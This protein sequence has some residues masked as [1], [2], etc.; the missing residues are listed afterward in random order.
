MKEK[1]VKVITK[2]CRNNFNH[3]SNT[4]KITIVTLKPIYIVTYEKQ[5]C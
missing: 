4:Q 2:Q 5:K 3:G 1:S